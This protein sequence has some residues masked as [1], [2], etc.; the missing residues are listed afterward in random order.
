MPLTVFRSYAADVWKQPG[1]CLSANRSVKRLRSIPAAP[2][3]KPR[4]KDSGTPFLVWLPPPIGG[5]TL[6]PMTAV[7][8]ESGMPFVPVATS[9]YQSVG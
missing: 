4:G 9:V 2:P 6:K 3:V 8:R 5:T 1:L 7:E